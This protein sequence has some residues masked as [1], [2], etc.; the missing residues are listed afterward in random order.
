MTKPTE[1]LNILPR[2]GAI[3]VTLSRLEES[4]SSTTTCIF[5]RSNGSSRADTGAKDVACNE[6]REYMERKGNSMLCDICL[7]FGVTC[8]KCK[9]LASHNNTVA[10]ARSTFRSFRICHISPPVAFSAARRKGINLGTS[11]RPPYGHH[12]SPRAISG[13]GRMALR[14]GRVWATSAAISPPPVAGV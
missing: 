1:P 3:V 13:P 14:P 6:H 11:G 4:A 12:I 7:E 2:A 5:C 8:I 9:F 10:V